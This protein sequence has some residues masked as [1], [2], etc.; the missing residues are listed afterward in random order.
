M[1]TCGGIEEDLMKCL[2]PHYLGEFCMPGKELYEQGFNRQ[3]NLLVPNNNY[4]KLFNWMMP[5]L[6]KMA[7]EQ[8]ENGTVWT[9]SKIIHRQKKSILML[10]EFSKSLSPA[11]NWQ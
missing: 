10:L 1:A 6:E 4:V 9:P 11:T 2:A 7:A 3:G 5:I 8:K